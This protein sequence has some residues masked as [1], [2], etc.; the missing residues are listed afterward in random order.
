MCPAHFFNRLDGWHQIGKY[1]A[2]SALD[3][4]HHDQEPIRALDIE[5]RI[6]YRPVCDRDQNMLYNA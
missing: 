1:I 6:F 2:M 4:R 3:F 5:L